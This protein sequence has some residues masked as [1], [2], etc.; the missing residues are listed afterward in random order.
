MPTSRQTH[1]ARGS[2]SAY[3]SDVP[4]ET[5]AKPLHASCVAFGQAGILIIGPSGAGKSSLALEL[6]AL[7]A[8]LVADDRTMV[9]SGPD[10]LVA[11][12]PKS[13][14]GRI[15]ARGVG[16]L[17]TAGCASAHIRLVVDLGQTERDRLPPFRKYKLMGQEVDLLHKV[18]CT[19]FAF[20]IKLY[21]T[22]G[23][24]E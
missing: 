13:I 18:E 19:S 7:G 11:S 17:A 14:A 8:G 6:M 9:A 5:A 3:R 22:A 10:G 20:A 23:R 12:A 16:I 2:W 4:V 24:V 15:E 21:I 1:L